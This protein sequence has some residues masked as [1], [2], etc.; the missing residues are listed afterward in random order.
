LLC[1]FIYNSYVFSFVF[2]EGY[3]QY[4]RTESDTEILSVSVTS[5]TWLS[6]NNTRFEGL[7]TQYHQY[8]SSRYRTRCYT[9][10]NICLRSRYYICLY[11]NQYVLSRKRCG[12]NVQVIMEFIKFIK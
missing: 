3:C 8:Y 4:Q 9:S 1:R 10:C 2:T 12:D 7:H 11:W 6:H 5:T